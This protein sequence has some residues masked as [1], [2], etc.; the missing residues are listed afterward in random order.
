[1]LEAVLYDEFSGFQVQLAV[2]VFALQ[3]LSL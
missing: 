2:L 3:V 1:M